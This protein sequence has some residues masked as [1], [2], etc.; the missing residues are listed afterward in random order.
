MRIVIISIVVAL[1]STL[2]AQTPFTDRMDKAL[3]TI[4]QEV[5]HQGPGVVIGIY[6]NGKLLQFRSKGK[7]NLDHQIEITDST[8][9]RLSST[10]K[11]FTAACIHHLVENGQLNLDDHIGDYFPELQDSL[12][13]ISVRQLLHHTSGLRDYLALFWLTGSQHM[14]FMRNFVGDDADIMEVL[15]GQNSLA[16]PSGSKHS[17]ANTNYWLLGQLVHRITDE[18]LGVYASEHFFKPLGMKNTF[19][20]EDLGKITPNKA[21]GY[22]SPCQECDRYE[23]T[24][25]PVTVGDQGVISNIQDLLLWEN[26]FYNHEILNDA[27]WKEMTTVGTLRDG[28]KTNY[29]SGLIVEEYR[30]QVIV[31]HSGQNPGFSSNL[32]RFPEQHLSIAVL[33]NQ[34]WFE[35]HGM[36]YQVADLFFPQEESPE[37]APIVNNPKPVL[38]TTKEQENL[39]GTYQ[40]QETGEIRSI[41]IT[42][43][44]LMYVRKNGPDSR[45]IAL[46]PTLLTFEDRPNVQMEISVS[47]NDQ[48]TI[49]WHD[50]P[51][52][53]HA[54]SISTEGL[55]TVNL[56]EFSGVFYNQELKQELIISLENQELKTDLFDQRVSLEITGKEAFNIMGMVRVKY[57]RDANQRI[58]GLVLDAPRAEGILFEKQDYSHP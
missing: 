15:T 39:C 5:D 54:S 6:K 51:R 40:Y 38:L 9:F 27:S 19:F 13:S 28:S 32:I 53:M 50:G 55:T 52:T 31:H 56:A 43:D 30:D 12:Q 35:V 22:I 49:L 41:A 14:D 16:F 2:Q 17:Y 36:A 46:S 24:Q 47:E 37:A 8:N 11:Q 48:K 33:G 44:G 3:D 10:A 23:Y 34:N 7:A 29:A 18:T 57:K 20:Y 4:L 26:E 45:L 21:S 1:S 25:D 58:C 42:E